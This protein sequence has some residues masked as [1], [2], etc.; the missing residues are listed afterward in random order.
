M[1]LNIFILVVEIYCLQKIFAT[2]FNIN[3][4]L[5]QL[6]L[7]V[8]KVKRS[9][10]IKINSD[11]SSS[12]LRCGYIGMMMNTHCHHN[13]AGALLTRRKCANSADAC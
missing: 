8:T 11:G 7:T 9:Q 12:E 3:S 1:K 5:L 10:T 13:R 2:T 6:Q 4:I